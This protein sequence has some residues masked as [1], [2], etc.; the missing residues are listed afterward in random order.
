MKALSTDLRKRVV[1][2]Y[3]AH[4]DEGT[5]YE[6]TAKHFAIGRATVDRWLRLKR[7][8]GD[9]EVRPRKVVE[10]SSLKM[11]WLKEHVEGNPDATLKARAKEHQASHGGALPSISAIWQALH[12]LGFT[13]QKKRSRRKR[14]TLRASQ[15]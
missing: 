14:R 2:Y 13:H 5:T 7:E 12:R 4:R 11:G 9:I 8:T 1:E 6:A 15:L 10:R 3:T